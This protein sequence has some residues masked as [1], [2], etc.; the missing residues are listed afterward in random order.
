[1]TRELPGLSA[2]DPLWIAE[3]AAAVRVV[4]QG[5]RALRRALPGRVVPVRTVGSTRI[6][7]ALRAVASACPMRCALPARRS[8]R[9]LP[10]R[11]VLLEHAAR[12]RAL[13]ARRPGRP[14]RRRPL[15]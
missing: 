6:E 4:G 14:R 13:A 8:R 7:N 9:R 5:L 15:G 1:M 10:R 3:P 11:R 12:R 2:V